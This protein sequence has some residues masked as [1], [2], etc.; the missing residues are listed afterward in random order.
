M[1]KA[2]STDKAPLPGGTYSPAIIHNG[3]AHI[4]GQGS[5]HTRHDGFSAG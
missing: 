5:F 1:R 4:S 2:I 3:I